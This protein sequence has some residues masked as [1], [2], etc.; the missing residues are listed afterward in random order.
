MLIMVIYSL[1]WFNISHMQGASDEQV[2]T[3]YAFTWTVGI[4]LGLR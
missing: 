2:E 3:G 4:K 1:I